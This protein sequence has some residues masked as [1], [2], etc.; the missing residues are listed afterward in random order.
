M[1]VSLIQTVEGLNRKETDVAWRRGNSVRRHLWTQT[2]SLPWIPSLPTYSR[3]WT[4]HQYKIQQ[5]F[6]TCWQNEEDAKSSQMHGGWRQ[7]SNNPLFYRMHSDTEEAVR[8]ALS[9]VFLYLSVYYQF[10]FL[11]QSSFCLASSEHLGFTGKLFALVSPYIV[12]NNLNW[13]CLIQMLIL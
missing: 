3:F 13:V 7:N 9:S 6:W 1:W 10:S 4:W 2:E 11:F 12:S 8:S 5:I